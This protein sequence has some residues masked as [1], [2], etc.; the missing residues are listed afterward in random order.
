MFRFRK[1]YLLVTIALFVVEILI[2]VSVHDKFVRPYVG[3]FLVVILLYSFFRS[4]LNL[5]FI[6]LAFLSLLI[7][8]TVELLQYFHLVQQLGLQNNTIA[9]T[10]V[11]SSA[12]WTDILAYTL[13]IAFVIGLERL[14]FS[15]TD[16]RLS[17]TSP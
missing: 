16:G 12:E 3:D 10:V 7:A 11:G 1:E 5:S 8:Y 17:T 2:A 9:R 13:G 15:K 4:F 6:R 14:R